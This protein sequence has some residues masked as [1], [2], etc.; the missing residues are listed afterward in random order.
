MTPTRKRKPRSARMMSHRSIFSPKDGD[1]FQGETT[2]TGSAA[3]EAARHRLGRLA[4]RASDLVSDGDTMEYLA[5]GDDETRL[6]LARRA[7]G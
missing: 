3:F 4:G 6:Y 1:R 5:R 7:K 2:A